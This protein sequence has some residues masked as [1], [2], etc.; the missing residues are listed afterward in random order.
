[1]NN[2]KR[3][4]LAF[5]VVFVSIVLD[6]ITKYIAQTTLADDSFFGVIG[7]AV[8]FELVHNPGAFLG[9]FS[10]AR[11]AFMLPSMLIIAIMIVWL[12]VKR[13]PS[14]LFVVA[15]SLLIGGGIANMIDRIFLGYVIDFISFKFIHFPNFN[16]ADS[17]VTVGCVLFAVCALFTKDDVFDLT[18]FTSKNTS[19]LSEQNKDDEQ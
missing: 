2:K 18:L 4:I 1:M 9:M 11:W 14:P 17:C 6:Q 15:V 10:D 7:D 19:T 12:Y 8:G 5:A 13:T 16:I 3:S